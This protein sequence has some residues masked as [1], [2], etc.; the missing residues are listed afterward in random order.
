MY[1]LQQFSVISLYLRVSITPITQL[2]Y[3]KGL[4]SLIFLSVSFLALKM[5]H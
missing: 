3:Q 2:I 4:L 1:E 5:G